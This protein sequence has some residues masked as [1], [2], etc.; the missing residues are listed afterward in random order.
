[1]RTLIVAAALA[2]S[3]AACK[4][5]GDNTYQ[6]QTPT[7]GVDTHIVKTPEVNVGTKTD[8]PGE[9]LRQPPEH[10]LDERLGTRPVPLH[11][12]QDDEA[13]HRGGRQGKGHPPH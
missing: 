5:T 7:I 12:D 9:T 6:V 1:M 11:E 4:K 3:V 2:L 13:E 8:P 10:P